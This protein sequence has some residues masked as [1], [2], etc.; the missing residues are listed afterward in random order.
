MRTNWKCLVFRASRSGWAIVGYIFILLK[1][2]DFITQAQDIYQFYMLIKEYGG[3]AIDFL[4][5]GWGTVTAFAM[6][7]GL[8][9]VAIWR[10][11]RQPEISFPKELEAN[12]SRTEFDLNGMEDHISFIFTV[13]N[14]TPHELVLTGENYGDLLFVPWQRFISP[15]RVQTK[16]GS[17]IKPHKKAIELKMIRIIE[18]GLAYTFAFKDPRY[19]KRNIE[20]V[21]LSFAEMKIGIRSS[22]EPFQHGIVKLPGETHIDVPDT[23]IHWDRYRK[24]YENLRG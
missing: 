6:G 13:D 21:I 14:P 11:S 4:G 7:F 17:I 22:Q 20:P 1:I 5:T 23:L 18:P 3:I 16:D 24:E 12:Y 19:M 15:W 8:I 2:V 10:T 9:I